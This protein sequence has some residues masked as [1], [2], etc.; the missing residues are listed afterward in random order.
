MVR[1]LPLAKPGCWQIRFSEQ[2]T[3]HAHQKQSITSWTIARR[4]MIDAFGSG[5]SCCM[6]GQTEDGDALYNEPLQER[7]VI[8]G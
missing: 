7:A 3:K 2:N 8:T 4:T 1:R 5:M 6:A